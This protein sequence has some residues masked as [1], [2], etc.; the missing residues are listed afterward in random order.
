MA[1]Y[2]YLY[3][4]N[5]G[6][7]ISLLE[8][9]LRFF[10]EQ[11][12]QLVEQ[13]NRLSAQLSAQSDHI[14]LLTNQIAT[15]TESLHSLEESLLD[16]ESSM[17]KARKTNHVLSKL[18]TNK[19]EKVAAARSLNGQA[20]E[21]EREVSSPKE[22]GN[23]NAKRKEHF[24]LEV[25]EH[26]IYP[27]LPGF[28]LE[29]ARL[30]KTVDSIRYEYIPPRYIKHINHLHYYLYQGGVVCGQLPATPLLNSSYDASFIAGIL[31]LRYIYSMPVERIVRFFTE[32]GF[33]MNKS[34]AHGL[35][36]KT[37]QLFDV[38]EETLKEAILEDDYLHMD[39][40]YYTVLEKG[41]KST[42]GKSS[43]KVYIWAALAGRTKLVHFFYENGSRA[44]KVLTDYIKPDY[45]G[46]IQCDGFS[47]YKIL[48]TQEYPHVIR[49]ACFQHCKRKFL[50]IPA[51]RDAQKIIEIINRLYQKEHERPLEYTPGQILE[52]RKEYA[53]PILEELK[54]NLLAI[55]AKKSTLPKSNLGK[56]VN[57]TLNEYPA[58]CNYMLKPEYE[59]DNN[60]IE[61]INRYISLS[62]R[63]SLFCGSHQG[64]K[65]AALI[66]SLACS[67][68]INGINT[69]EYFKDILNKFV[70]VNP[71]TN[72][73]DLR[74][75]LPDKWKK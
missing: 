50:D 33:E 68:R 34:T 4:M 6:R 63:N 38:L 9:Q 7:I 29:L 32:N 65:R 57:Y 42:T 72:K 37:A 44:R 19:S 53:P 17:E 11:N 62:R 26:D 40:S 46:A 64:A 16:K 30:L 45:R 12:R 61:R 55:Q 66:Y 71:N 43:C 5:Y 13:N 70:F 60:A 51:N 39:E 18:I 41:P 47:D 1:Y 21:R 3:I 15:L 74:E 14:C 59:L 10:Q 27:S 23:N 49:L 36:K 75:L 69:F 20:E 56:A 8:E 48:E 52:Y 22:R 73:E 24:E 54:E 25:Q 58:L 31:Q 35:I 67:C 2:P 28:P